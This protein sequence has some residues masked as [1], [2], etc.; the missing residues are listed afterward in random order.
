MIYMKN[1][2][3]YSIFAKITDGLLARVIDSVLTI[4]QYVN[5]ISGKPIGRIKYSLG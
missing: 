2:R 5:I 4:L 3:F 1:Q